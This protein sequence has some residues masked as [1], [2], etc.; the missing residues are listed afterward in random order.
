MESQITKRGTTLVVPDDPVIPFIEG[1][2]IGPDI[3]AAA[4]RVFDEIGAIKAAWDF[5]VS[6]FGSMAIGGLQCSGLEQAHHA[7]FLI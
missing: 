7:D 5:S 4:V 6:L 3:W 1:D 2:G